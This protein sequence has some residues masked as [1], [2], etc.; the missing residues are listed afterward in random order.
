MGEVDSLPPLGSGG[1]EREIRGERNETLYDRGVGR[2]RE[3]RYLK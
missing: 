2:F 1:P 3:S